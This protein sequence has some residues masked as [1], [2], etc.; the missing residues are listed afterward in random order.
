MAVVAPYKNNFFLWALNHDFFR[1]ATGF[2]FCNGV[3]SDYFSTTPTGIPA[4]MGIQG[5]IRIILNFISL[6]GRGVW[7]PNTYSPCSLIRNIR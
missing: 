6:Y 3:F 1:S 7:I 4:S 2:L 5:K